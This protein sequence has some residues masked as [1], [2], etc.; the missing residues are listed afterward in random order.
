[1]VFPNGQERNEGGVCEIG[2]DVPFCAIWGT[3][4]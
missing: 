1:M 4:I 2:T 3:C